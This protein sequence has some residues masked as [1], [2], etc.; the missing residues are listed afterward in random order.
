M[1]E[2]N[3]RP[4]IKFELSQ[5]PEKV[6]EMLIA[7]EQFYLKELQFSKKHNHC[8]IEIHP[9]EQHYWS[10]YATFN[11][12]KT[13]SGTIVRGI[14]G[15]RPNLWASFMVLYVF[16]LASFTTTAV[17]GT[18]MISLNKSGILLYISPLFLCLFAATYLAAQ[19]GKAKAS[20]QTKKIK[21]FIQSALFAHDLSPK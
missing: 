8:T 16:S 4:R 1:S 15:P 7:H 21:D 19:F 9:S 10:P 3:V 14:V 17:I 5:D 11:L 13:E 12:E 18:G 2:I 20:S 6:R